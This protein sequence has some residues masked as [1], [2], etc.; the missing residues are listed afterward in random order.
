ME[1]KVLTAISN[2]DQYQPKTAGEVYPLIYKTDDEIQE[3][4]KYI[5]V[6]GWKRASNVKGARKIGKYHPNYPKSNTGIE[7]FTRKRTIEEITSQMDAPKKDRKP[8]KPISLYRIDRK[9]KKLSIVPDCSALPMLSHFSDFESLV[10]IQSKSN[11]LVISCD[12]E[13]VS[14]LSEERV[15]LTFQFAVI[16]GNYL[17]E[18]IFMVC[19]PEAFLKLEFCLGF[20][21][22]YLGLYEGVKGAD[23]IHYTSC[24]E[25]RNGKPAT[26]QYSYLELDEAR[27]SAKYKYI[28]GEF[29]AERIPKDCRTKREERD[30]GYFHMATDFTK[31]HSIPV[32]LLCHFGRIDISGFCDFE[33]H[34]RKCSDVQGGTVTMKSYQICPECHNKESYWKQRDRNRYYPVSIR[35]SDTM[36]HAPAEMK[37]LENLGDV[38]GVPKVDID[39]LYPKYHYIKHIHDLLIADP[40]TFFEYAGTD[41]VVTLL[42]A[43][44]LYGYNKELPVTLTSATARYLCSRIMTGLNVTTKEAFNR[45]YR[46]LKNVNRGTM[47]AENGN[48]APVSSLEPISADAGVIQ[49]LAK[50]AYHGGYN[51]CSEIG[52][53][54][55]FHTYDYD[56]CSAYSSIMAMIPDVDWESLIQKEITNRK[57]TLEDWKDDSGN[58]D[59]TKVGFFEVTFSFHDEVAYPCFCCM[60]DGVPVYPRSSEGYGSAYVSAQDIYLA[61]QLGADVF[62]KRDYFCNLLI[63]DSGNVSYSLREGVVELIRDRSKAKKKYGKKSLESALLF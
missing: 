24:S 26:H 63:D 49:S 31:V 62:C 6:A 12:T 60:C 32:T 18:F 52:S 5:A 37:K 29:V 11:S 2:E 15:P 46:G 48:L 14:C 55:G 35:F 44:S 17:I 57:L 3:I 9:E 30:W 27:K 28:Q 22:D 38:V 45:K 23:I 42:Y 20:I 34:M 36:C 7:V 47:E 40:K 8:S 50:N 1:K 41:A 10:A 19:H 54:H 25:F 33:R 16:D 58:L 43:S 13:F 61:L 53:Y 51:G 59:L 39:K 21:L 56:I 4:S